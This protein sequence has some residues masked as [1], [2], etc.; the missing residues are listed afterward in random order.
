MHLR[1]LDLLNWC[2]HPR[3]TV[4]FAPGLNAII[5]PNG[6]GKSNILNAVRWLLTGNN[7]NEGTLAENVYQL[8]GAGERASASLAFEHNGMEFLV[9]KHLRPASEKSRLVIP[10][11]D[12]V[13]GEREVNARL[14]DLWGLDPKLILRFV[15]VAQED[16]AGFLADDPKERALTFQRLFDT[17][18]A[19]Q[20]HGVCSKHVNKLSFPSVGSSLDSVRSQ[21]SAAREKLARFEQQLVGLPTLM[22]LD[23]TQT[24]ARAALQN[25][26]N[27]SQ[28]ALQITA[29]EQQ[30]VVTSGPLAQEQ[31][32]L[33]RLEDDL[34]VLQ[35]AAANEQT[36][37][38]A[39]KAA[40]ANWQTHKRV[41]ASR[42]QLV[43]Q[44][45]ELEQRLASQ[46]RPTPPAECL[47]DVPSL[48]T[49]KYREAAACVRAYA[50]E[51][52]ELQHAVRHRQTLIAQFTNEGVAACPTCDTPTANIAPT[53]ARYQTE[54]AELEP[55]IQ[56]RISALA[57]TR[58][59][60]DRFR[61]WLGH[62]AECDSLLAQLDTTEKQLISVAAPGATEEALQ[63]I[64]GSHQEYLDTIREMVPRVDQLRQ[65]INTR[66]GSLTNQREQLGRLQTAHGSCLINADQARIAEA[67]LQRTKEAAAIRGPL[68][69]LIPATRDEITRLATDEQRL[70]EEFRQ[71]VI[72]QDWIATV[73]EY[74]SLF[75]YNG[76]PKFVAQRNLQ[77]LQV[78]IND[79][80][81]Q[82][83]VDFRVTADEGLSF[84]GN[85]FDGRT[86]S[87]RRFSGGQKV[88][89]AWAMRLALNAQFA[90]TVGSLWLD[91]PTVWLDK[92]RIAALS[93]VLERLRA[94]T[95]SRGLQ[96]VLIT[97]E[98]DLAP[99]FENV[100]SL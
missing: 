100:I 63:Q 10:G 64:V 31:A 56:K 93:P 96:C 55:A 71:S 78:G 3:L 50:E 36:G 19:D 32:E 51:T 26:A 25:W 7:G 90:S 91:E 98:E 49:T 92:R 28:Y 2:N 13:V 58:D 95:A 88:S 43:Q 17:R 8:A 74:K 21:L 23:V 67:E 1:R 81:A 39:A 35:Q 12:D 9:T 5:G 15:L 60:L 72:G 6:S 75:H 69:A 57:Q 77:E 53:I 70:V 85:F 66:Q 62:A 42:Q 40:I 80:L 22:E 65:I 84:M 48:V 83:D 61:A 97:H 86:Q 68:D 99:L 87:A 59:Y 73:E 45:R 46:P 52:S 38:D 37:A 4:D 44:R 27:K 89:L 79:V 94:L 14:A 54:L 33:A 76:A 82:L 18:Q 20:I 24:N 16:I 29:Q 34:R 30:I 47:P 11:K 41:E